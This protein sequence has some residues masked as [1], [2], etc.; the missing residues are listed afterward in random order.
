[1]ALRAIL[2]DQYLLPDTVATVL[3]DNVDP[4]HIVNTTQY[5]AVFP[6]AKIAIYAMQV[7]KLTRRFQQQCMLH[8]RRSHRPHYGLWVAGTRA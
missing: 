8:T 5:D 1:M 3:G 6:L 4:G 2:Q 7:E